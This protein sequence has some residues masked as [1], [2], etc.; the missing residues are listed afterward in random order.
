MTAA[1]TLAQ[2][3]YRGGRTFAEFGR[4]KALVR[5]GRAVLSGTE[6]S[7]LLDAVAAYLDVVRD[8]QAVSYRQDNVS[9]LEDQLEAEN[10]QLLAGAITQTDTAQTES[11]LALARSGLAV[12]EGQLAAS[13]ARF[14]RAVGQPAVALE[15]MPPLPELPGSMVEAINRGI[16]SAPALIAA[17]ENVVAANYAIDDA[18]GALLPTISLSLQYQYSKNAAVLGVISPS[19]TQRGPAAFVQVTIPIYQGGF[20]QAQVR[21]SRHQQSQSLYNVTDIERQVRQAVSSTWGLL[22]A[23]QS[24]IIS[25]QAQVAA[26]TTALRGVIE[27]QRAG[28]RTVLEILNAQQELLIAQLELA[29]ARHDAT[30]IGY[31]LLASTGGLSAGS[32]GLDVK[33]Y[34]PNEHFD[35]AN[36]SFFSSWFSLRDD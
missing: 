10:S 14:E 2:P 16:A 31:Q 29:N 30:V 11:R 33:L 15:D 4:A 32:L 3:I 23:A 13:R 5:A 36:S 25:D 26:S 18:I 21:Q 17:K 7:V 22:Q 28:E 34:D 27:E 8:Q 24:A 1:F 9:V 6:Q 35:R 20:A 19:V 12:A